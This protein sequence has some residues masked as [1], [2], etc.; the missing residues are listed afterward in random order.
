MKKKTESK[1][2]KER[3]KKQQAKLQFRNKKENSPLPW[4]KNQR[5]Q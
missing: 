1:E 3:K 2:R 5:Q 4:L